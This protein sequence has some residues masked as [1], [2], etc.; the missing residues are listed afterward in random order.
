MLGDS[1]T[2]WPVS[3][4]VRINVLRAHWLLKQY[5]DGLDEPYEV[6]GPFETEMQMYRFVHVKSAFVQFM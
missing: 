1:E 5:H 4:L 2:T 6:R 3:V